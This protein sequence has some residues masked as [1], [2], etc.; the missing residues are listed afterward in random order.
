MNP[1][2]KLNV[3]LEAQAWEMVLR[4][5][6][7]APVPH[8]IVNPLIVEIQAQCVKQAT[9]EARSPLALVPREAEE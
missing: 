5:L 8:E 1:T 2:D 7:K 9:E 4:V 6:A 3:I